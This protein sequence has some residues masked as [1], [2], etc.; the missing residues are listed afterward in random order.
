MF[1]F[2]NVMPVCMVMLIADPALADF[3]PIMPKINEAAR[4]S[5][6]NV[7]AENDFFKLIFLMEFYPLLDKRE[8][9]AP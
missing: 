2:G 1:V 3:L 9:Y 5:V 6:M 4:A 7:S 8:C